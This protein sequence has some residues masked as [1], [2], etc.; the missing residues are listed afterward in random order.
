LKR[1]FFFSLTLAIPILLVNM[2]SMT[3]WFMSLVPLSMDEV[4]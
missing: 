1:E 3:A 4:N 2:L